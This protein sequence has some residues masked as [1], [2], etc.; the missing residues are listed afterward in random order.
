MKLAT[1]PDNTAIKDKINT[2]WFWEQPLCKSLWCKCS[3]SGVN[4]ETPFAILL[5]EEKVI[6]IIGTDKIK[7]GTNIVNATDFITP[8]MDKEANKNPANNAPES[9]MKIFAG[10]KL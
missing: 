6:S 8:V 3:A 2:V 9:P 10:W 7:N 5:N 4:G 1:A